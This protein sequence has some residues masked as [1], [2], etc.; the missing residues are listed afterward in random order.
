MFCRAYR[1]GLDSASEGRGQ[2]F[3]SSR[4]PEPA[5]PLSPREVDAMTFLALGY[6]RAQVAATLVISEHTLRVYI[7][8]ARHKLGAMNTVHAVT[9]ALSRGLIVV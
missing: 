4:V 2:R 3:E 8:S 6:S 1:K 5:Q 9:K 7:E